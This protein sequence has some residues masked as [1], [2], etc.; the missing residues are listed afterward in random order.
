MLVLVLPVRAES[1]G[2]T[3][4]GDELSH[5]GRHSSASL[6]ELDLRYDDVVLQNRA[7][8]RTHGA[9]P[10]LVHVDV[11]PAAGPTHPGTHGGEG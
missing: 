3:V 4:S 7:A 9:A 2:L 11:G 10:G 8:A 6:H 1:M 5:G